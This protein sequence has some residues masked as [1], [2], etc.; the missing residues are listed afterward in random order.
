MSQSTQFDQV[1]VIKKANIFFDGK[2]IRHTVMLADGSQKTL[3]VMLPPSVMHFK[4]DAPERI[5]VVA[6][7]CLVKLANEE[8]YTSYRAGQSFYVPGNSAFDL[9]VQEPMHYV[10]HFEG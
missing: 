7:E 3:G 2:C 5:E 8:G 10:C 9:Q 1:S 4:T 6:G